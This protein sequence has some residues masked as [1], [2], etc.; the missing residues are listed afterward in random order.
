MIPALLVASFINSCL[1]EATMILLIPVFVIFWVS[2][3]GMPVPSL[4]EYVIVEWL[5]PFS[6]RAL[7]IP[8][9]AELAFPFSLRT[10][11]TSSGFLSF[12]IHEARSLNWASDGLGA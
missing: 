6:I 1:S 9:P 2:L 7:T 4:R 12:W 10:I 8:S 11:I 3:E 5:I